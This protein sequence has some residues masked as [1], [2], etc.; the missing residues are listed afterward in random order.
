MAEMSVPPNLRVPEGA[1]PE[2]V[3]QV[4]RVNSFL[5]WARTE[6]KRMEREVERL[7]KVRGTMPIHKGPGGIVILE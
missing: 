3:R 1:D 4:E 2:H 5:A 6:M 7:G